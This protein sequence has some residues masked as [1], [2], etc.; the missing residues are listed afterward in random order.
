M[1]KRI[2]IVLDDDL[3]KKLREKQAKKII[4]DNIYM[5]IAS[6]SLDGKPWV[7][8]VFFAYDD[9]YNLYWVS[10]K[11]S[12]HSNLIR[13][14][15]KVAVVIFNS[16]VPEGEGDGVYVDAQAVELNDVR[17]AKEAMSIL[18]ARVTQ[19]EFRI[20]KIGEVTEEGVWRIYK[21]TPQSVSKLKEG[22]YAN[23]QYVDRRIEINL[24]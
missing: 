15:K 18:S 9:S 23:G 8:P 20:K 10:D 11:N 1:G 16:K 13:E 21:A 7:S 6:A 19:E 22:E 5:T 17:E 3:Q 24:R 2:T 12:R 4:A 14:N